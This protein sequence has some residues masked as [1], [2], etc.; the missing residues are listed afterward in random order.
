MRLHSLYLQAFGPFAGEQ[1]VDFERLASGGLFLL[2]GPTGAGKS[3]ILDAVTFALYGAPAADA[4]PDRLHS[5]F[6]S[7]DL[8]PRVRLELSV[9]GRRY[10]ISRSPEWE[11]PKR[12]GEGRTR[13]AAAV[14]LERREH[15]SWTSVS[16]NKAEVGEIIG[17]V[18]GLNRDQFTQVVLLPQ[19]EFARFLRADDDDRRLVLT[20]LFGTALYDRVTDELTRRRGQARVGAE[21][22]EARV[23]QCLSAAAEAAGLE[24][25]RR[26]ELLA[27]PGAGRTERLAELTLEATAAAALAE[28]A[29][30]EQSARLTAAR[31]VAGEAATDLDRLE[32]ALAARAA[33]AEHERGRAQ[34]EDAVQRLVLARSAEPLRPLL[35]GME[36]AVAGAD[37][38]RAQVAPLAA[39]WI[40]AA[41]QAVLPRRELTTADLDDAAGSRRAARTLGR[42]SIE[43][44]EET[45]RLDP[46]VAV[47]A[48][49]PRR[50][51]ALTNAEAAAERAAKRLAE[52]RDRERDL[53]DLLALARAQDADTAER[54]GQ[55]KGAR[56]RLQELE[57]RFTA[58]TL[59]GRLR[60]EQETRHAELIRAIDAHQSAVD[61]HQDLLARQLA[62]MAAELAARLAPGRACGVCGSTVHPAPARPAADAVGVRHLET[63]ER[64]RAAAR[65][66]RA[67]AEAALAA[68]ATELATALATA[69]I[70]PTNDPQDA[71]GRLGVAIDAAHGAVADAESAVELRVETLTRLT[72]LEAEYG[73]LVALVAEAAADAALTAAEADSARAALTQAEELVAEEVDGWTTVAARRAAT[74]QREQ[75]AGT[76][77][78]ALEELGRTLA[79]RDRAV[80][81][82]DAA[83]AEHGFVDVDHARAAALPPDDQRVV[84]ARTRR[85][86]D[87]LV[88]RRARADDAGLSAVD[89]EEVDTVRARAVAATSDLARAESA[90]RA[91]RDRAGQADRS[92]ARLTARVAEVHCAV[93]DA[94]A[95]DVQSRAVIHLADLA[96]GMDGH[97]RMT[98]TTYVL[99]RWFGQVVAA[100]NLRLAA[101]SSGRY[102]L[103]RVDQGARARDR[104]GLTLSVIDE[105][106]GEARDPR[107]LSGGE[108]F[109]T[110]LALAL[111]LADVV[112]AEAGGVDLDTLFIDE[113]FGSLD[114][115]TL[116]DVMAVVDDLRDRGR[117]VGI[118]SH[119]TEL[120]DRIPERLEIRRRSDGSSEVRLIA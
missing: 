73:R 80:A 14:H 65:L 113:G 34:Y 57:R 81:Q 8:E 19:G 106:T 72:E 36:D 83:A 61:Q 33:V 77:A 11:R 103:R 6:A 68:G 39:H 89:V 112:T 42:V 107:S 118:V 119:V 12:R 28:T 56:R 117:V 37:A 53:P 101:M 95:Q 21:A 105:H 64:D 76:L 97:L 84:E 54:A 60:R 35:A 104:G 98:L 91:A 59:A 16:S 25:D 79:A 47:E 18:I 110:S 102:A 52:R 22:A 96:R 55:L 43:A 90:D 69:G 116:D 86:A 71:A 94:A 23:R 93:A 38:W 24:A 85:W 74:A 67:T 41:A 46:V 88:R 92:M 5:D 78:N 48:A 120:K 70:E 108:T 27:A 49:L 51:D 114:A 99:R 40:S 62:G 75:A 100:A 66:R 111:G 17:E 50:R 115:D 4:S 32:R 31:A 9:R 10:R 26:A 30:A 2:E 29:A 3:T 63:A 82:A 44:R 58:A 15:G 20:R 45:Y 13:Q 109:Y 87:E 7:P 1:Y